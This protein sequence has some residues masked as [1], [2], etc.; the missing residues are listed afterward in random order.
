MTHLTQALLTDFT[1]TLKSRYR[2]LWADVQNDLANARPYAELAGEAH[3][4]EDEATADVLV[5]VNLADIH[6][7]IGEMRDIEAALQRI[8][9]RSYGTCTDCAADIALERLRAWPTAKRC[10]DCQARYERLHQSTRGPT[11]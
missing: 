2:E 8:L 5:D 6:L 11:L 4:R 7:R 3:D 9:D 10:R 1:R